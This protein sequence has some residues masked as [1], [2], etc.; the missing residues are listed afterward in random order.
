MRVITCVR[1]VSLHCVIFPK[2]YKLQKELC[3]QLLNDNGL[4]WKKKY[5]IAFKRSREG[6]TVCWSDLPFT[7]TIYANFTF[8]FNA[9]NFF[10][11]RALILPMSL[12]VKL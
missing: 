7:Q 2:L 11:S 10:T 9:N 3:A 8:I 4:C 5:P 6:N 12:S 1:L